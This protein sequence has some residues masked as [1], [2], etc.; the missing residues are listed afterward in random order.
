MHLISQRPTGRSAQQREGSEREGAAGAG[1]EGRAGGGGGGATSAKGRPR[2]TGWGNSC[3]WMVGGSVESFGASPPRKFLPASPPPPHAPSFRMVGKLGIRPGRS[4]PPPPASRLLSPAPP[5]PAL[6]PTRR[7]ALAD[8]LVAPL[9]SSFASAPPQKN[10][11]SPHATKVVSTRSRATEREPLR[12]HGHPSPPADESRTPLLPLHAPGRPPPA[13][14]RGPR[15]GR[16]ARVALSTHL[17]SPAARPCHPSPPLPHQFPSPM[18]PSPARYRH[19]VLLAS[20]SPASP[21]NSAPRSPPRRAE[22]PRATRPRGCPTTLAPLRRSR[23]LAR[24]PTAPRARPRSRHCAADPPRPPK[25]SRTPPRAPAAAQPEKGPRAGAAERSRPAIS[26]TRCIC[27]VVAPIGGSGAR[28]A[29]SAARG[30]QVGRDGRAPTHPGRA[31]PRR[32][33]GRRAPA[34]VVARLKDE[35]GIG[36][37]RVASV[38]FWQRS[39][40]ASPRSPARR[41]SRLGAQSA[42]PAR[43][44][45]RAEQE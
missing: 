31:R 39:A 40:P 27:G 13:R 3:W 44:L 12:L 36:S 19:A 15:R 9:A 45:Y 17:C 11:P 14:R 18:P 10:K 1:E 32:R 5:P 24:R 16:C 2:A 41:R 43:E 6:P 26:D 25:Y 4:E 21:R 28:S 23:P 33:L 38:F 29:P 30:R 8:L 22:T 37:S 34:T 7:S 35:R 20:A 42:V